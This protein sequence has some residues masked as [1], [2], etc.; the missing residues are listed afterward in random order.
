MIEN[1]SLIIKANK[2]LK[3][4]NKDFLKVSTFIDGLNK[5]I[6]KIHLSI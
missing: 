3:N 2:Y 1:K 5:I 6:N 4:M